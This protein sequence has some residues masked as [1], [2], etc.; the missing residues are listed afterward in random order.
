MNKLV[1]FFRFFMLGALICSAVCCGKDDEVEPPVPL[2]TA[3]VEIGAD[4]A[5]L[6]FT[7]DADS[8]EITVKAN[9][10][11]AVTVDAA[12]T[13]WLTATI[14]ATDAG[15]STAKLTLAVKQN[16]DAY[17]GRSATVSLAAIATP[18]REAEDLT[19]S[20]ASAKTS[21][22]LRQSIF[23]LPTA[24]LLDVVFTVGA[25]PGTCA[26]RDISP[27]ANVITN[28]QTNGDSDCN[29]AIPPTVSNN[30]LY[31]RP[32]AHFAGG[33]TCN[34][35]RSSSYYRVDLVNYGIS[36][37]TTA[38]YFGNGNVNNVQIP[39]TALGQVIMN[40]AYSVE[41]I[42]KPEAF[43]G[44]M[45][46][47]TQSCGGSVGSKNDGIETNLSFY[48]DMAATPLGTSDTRNVISDEGAASL[49]RYSHLIGVYDK[50]NNA[51]IL[52][53]DGAEAKRLSS[54][55]LVVRHNEPFRD[56]NALA[57]WVGIGGNCRRADPIVNGQS[58]HISTSYENWATS[59]F[60]G[61]IVLA[62]FYGRALSAT[63]VKTLY[64]YEKPE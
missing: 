7:G 31:G 16:V 19:V 11:V 57:Q 29:V 24:D 35:S 59:M 33:S 37:L 22:G 23:G 17:K 45:M 4:D 39:Y 48:Q 14:T 43:G 32:T 54:A 40:D 18:G 36:D 27:A 13:A 30:A 26:A 6:L 53:L 38:Y 8:R 61:E 55:G 62:R 15:T 52:Y 51:V 60:K 3:F 58:L 28:G 41:I 44:N 1:S 25:T 10:E 46:G 50:A 56:Q 5:S 9:R 12:A 47:W 42:F 34:G 20:G 49:D 63:E 21:L 64:E 2:V